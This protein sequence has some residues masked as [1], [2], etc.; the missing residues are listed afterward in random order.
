MKAALN[1]ILETQKEIS[2]SLQK[3]VVLETNHQYTREGLQ[4]A[5]TEISD[6]KNEN[7]RIKEK[8][9]DID[10]QLPVLNLV[11]RWVI[12]GVTTTVAM[13][14]AAVVSLVVMVADR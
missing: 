3:M 12:G 13:V 8:I 7:G 14:G 6:L 11:K 4:R 2:E 1:G 5:F 9:N 10:K